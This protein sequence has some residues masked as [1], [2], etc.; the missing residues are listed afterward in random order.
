MD[1][2][3]ERLRAY[4]LHPVT[5]EAADEIERLRKEIKTADDF[6][7]LLVAE[8]ESKSAPAIDA[9]AGCV[10]PVAWL[11]HRDQWLALADGGVFGHGWTPL[12]AAAPPQRQ[13]LSD[14]EIDTLYETC[15]GPTGFGGHENDTPER[16]FD[17]HKFARA[18]EAAHGIKETK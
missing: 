15:L 8:L 11:R 10:E 16:V 13:P 12:Y 14:E 2:I 9:S 6:S 17:V 4:R 3:V 1:D 7:R 18:V 5:A